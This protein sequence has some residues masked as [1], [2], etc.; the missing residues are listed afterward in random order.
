[1]KRQQKIYKHAKAVDKREQE[2]HAAALGRRR[3]PVG[4]RGGVPFEFL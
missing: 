4:E 2:Q 1:M 3:R